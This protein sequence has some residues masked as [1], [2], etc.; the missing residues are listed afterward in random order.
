MAQAKKK[1]PEG[2]DVIVHICRNRR[3]AFNYTLMDAVECGVV[4]VGTEVKSLRN[5][6]ANLEDSYAHLTNGELWLMGCEIPEY[7]QGNKLNHKPK[8]ERKLL[9]HKRE[10]NKF[11]GNASE[12]GFTLIPTKMY[13]KNGKVKVEIAVAKGKQTHDKRE[14]VKKNE[15]KREIARAMRTKSKR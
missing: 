1:V 5:G 14:T 3:A 9:L 13:F 6:L 4:L 2:E 11:A 15:A 8:R 10:I 7:T 12:K